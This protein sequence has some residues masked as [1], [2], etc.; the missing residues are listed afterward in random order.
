MSIYAATFKEGVSCEIKTSTKDI[1]II[2]ANVS[3]TSNSRKHINTIYS[4][5]FKKVKNSSLFQIR[6]EIFPAASGLGLFPNID[7][8]MGRSSQ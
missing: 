6:H 8:H 7:D 4:R 2:N 5:S 3:D 1:K